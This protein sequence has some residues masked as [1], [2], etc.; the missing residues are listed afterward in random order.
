MMYRMGLSTR[1]LS[2]LRRRLIGKSISHGE[3]SNVNAELTD[4]VGKLRTHDLSNEKIKNIFVDGVHFD[5]KIDVS[6]KNTPVLVKTGVSEEGIKQ[7]PEVQKMSMPR[8]M[9]KWK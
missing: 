8:F 5:M 1:T 4:T 3:I 6:T 7:V 2:M 9:K